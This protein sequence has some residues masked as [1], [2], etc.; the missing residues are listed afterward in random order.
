MNFCNVQKYNF[1]K[2]QSQQFPN[3]CFQEKMT[4]IMMT[5]M[6][7]RRMEGARNMTTLIKKGSACEMIEN[8]KNILNHKERGQWGEKTEDRERN[9]QEVLQ[10]V[11]FFK[12]FF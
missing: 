12:C 8:K 3:S 9:H 6:T 7:E 1:H 4:M 10:S 11:D 2:S 5:M